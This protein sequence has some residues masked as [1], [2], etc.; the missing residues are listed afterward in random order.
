MIDELLNFGLERANSSIIKVI[1]V[2]G[3]GCNAVK[4]MFEEGIEG[5]D[6]IICN[7]D[8]QAMQNNPVPVRIQLGVTLTE[9]RGA[10]N[11]PEQGEHAAIENLRDVRE[12][13]EGTT[14]MVFIT[15]GMGGG[16]GTGAAPVIARLAQE[17]NILT[18]AVVTIPSRSEG[19][20]RFE[21]ALDGVEKLR[22]YVDSMLVI[23]NEKLHKIYGNLPA[24]KAFKKADNIITTAVKGVAEII[25]LHGNINIDFADVSTVMAGSKVFLMGTGYAEGP[26]R[27]MT[28]VKLALES[29]LLDISSIRGTKDIL[30]NIIS[31]SEEITMGE[32]GEIIDYLQNEAAQEATIIWGNGCDPKLGS[33]ISVTIIATGFDVSQ[34]RM[35][36]SNPT[37]I[38]ELEPEKLEFDINLDDAEDLLD[39]ML[40]PEVPK[41]PIFEVNGLPTY[42]AGK[43]LHTEPESAILDLTAAVA[44]Q[45]RV[46]RVAEKAA[47]KALKAEQA[48]AKAAELAA[49][50]AAKE[51]EKAAKKAN[52]KADSKMSSETNSEGGNVDG[53]FTRQFSKF[54]EEKDSS[55]PEGN[56][57]N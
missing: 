50:K 24:S 34:N 4:N 29:P 25:T 19:K 37:E 51:A 3:G 46:D 11:L 47:E 18:I 45:P 5:V 13:L 14:K 17:L 12:V 48:A 53:W 44:S 35:Y 33:Q 41:E 16:T 28:A 54:F 36:Q 49:A 22:E 27:A 57:K 38:I 32:I 31:G 2:G 30:L 56:A 9:G 7:T 21:Q 20:R 10:G 26:D 42:R 6:F 8:A 1:G 15:A 55:T 40:K 23:N 43:R 52:R 39:A